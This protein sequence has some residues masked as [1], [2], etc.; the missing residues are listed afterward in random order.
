LES[1][2]HTASRRSASAPESDE[3]GQIDP[4][5]EKNKETL[6]ANLGNGVKFAVSLTVLLL[7][8][9][10]GLDAKPELPNLGFPEFTTGWRPGMR[11][12][13]GSMSKMRC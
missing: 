11:N 2:W 6:E 1:K 10:T 8:P 12:L 5:E 9:G 13:M 7:L 4:V 3:A